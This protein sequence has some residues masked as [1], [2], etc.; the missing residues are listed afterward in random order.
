MKPITLEMTAFGSYAETARID[1]SKFRSGIF[2][3]TGDTG[4]G[5]TTIFDAIVF[6]LYGTPSG[7]DRKADMM[8]CD[9]VSKSQ[10]TEVELCF[11]QGGR[12][13]KVKRT[14]HY[15]KKRGSS[16]EYSDE[17][18]IDG[19]LIEPDGQTVTVS[20]KVT[21]RITE[22][23][24]L[25]K[26]QF[27]Q[28]VMLA[29]GEFKQFLKSD[30]E[31]K[32]EILGKLFDNSVYLCY[33]EMITRAAQVLR[34]E[35]KESKEKIRTAMEQAFQPSEETG[36][37]PDDAWLPESPALTE[38]LEKLICLEKED[39]ESAGRYRMKC[40]E[41]REALLAELS[42]ADLHN[43]LLNELDDK[44]KIL[45]GLRARTD[46]MADLRSR[47]AKIKA[48]SRIVSPAGKSLREAEQGLSEL[49]AGIAGLKESLQRFEAE[50]SAAEE[51]VK[52]D[53]E[54]RTRADSLEAEIRSLRESLPKY[55]ELK[56]L[57]LTVREKKEA[58]RRDTE[59]L[60]K[61]KEQLQVLLQETLEVRA[62][63]DNIYRRYIEGQA[64]IL[65]EGLRQE[66]NEKGGALCPVCGTR[67][68]P[69]N[70]EHLAH[71][72]EDAPS[73]ESLEQARLAFE[74]KDKARNDESGRLQALTAKIDTEKK[75]VDSW[76]EDL[77]KRRKDLPFAGK[78]EVAEKIGSLTA[79]KEDLRRRIEAHMNEKEE[80][81][82][83]FNLVRGSLDTEQKKLPVFRNRLEQA[84]SEYERVLEETGFMTPDAAAA[85]AEGIRDPEAWI[86]DAEK[87]LQKYEADV[88]GLT[89]RT[90]ELKIQT[91]DWVLKDLTVLRE[92]A[93]EAGS[94]YDASNDAWNRKDSLLGNHEKIFAAVKAEK[95]KLSAGDPAWNVLNRLSELASGATG[96][97]GKLSFDRYVMGTVFREIIE[98]ANF[99]LEILS[100]GQYQLVHQTGAYR[101]NAKAG[102]DLEVLDRN[103]GLQRESASLSGGESFIVSLALALG[104]SDTVRSRSGGQALDTMFIDE[105]FGTLDDD[106]LDKA[107]QVLDSLSDGSRHLVGIIS[108]VSRLEESIVQKIVVTNGEKGSS[109]RMSGIESS[110]G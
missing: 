32:S 88:R 42:T 49:E 84:R 65:A 24:G 70:A 48:F 69:E 26:D 76:Q 17:A 74:E 35:R 33:E 15:S 22:I 8:H 37:F 30:S 43:R 25:N 50:K 91:K 64:G 28:I 41:A 108:H 23:L 66:L 19:V 96:E 93:D 100:G 63:Y 55:E 11:E 110:Y 80:A 68:R 6:A 27:R 79:E 40:Q 75:N 101:K 21:D 52:N 12:E 2:L 77:E 72:E 10:D 20:G 38:N 3:V 102:L 51:A 13:Y 4:A 56:K 90:E 86:T 105:G 29:Q 46:E 44:T 60:A 14:L 109:L 31:K 107:I 58:V 94:R 92:Q 87:S 39:L 103:T 53:G 71:A 83:R 106:T 36:A 78:E 73:Q 82:K 45:D 47:T 5:K 89:E 62:Y 99:R 1:F 81:Q 7:P 16:N 95:E 104:L 57:E 59:K 85:A 97:G 67:I 54:A 34:E 18:K 98:K 61:G 9:H